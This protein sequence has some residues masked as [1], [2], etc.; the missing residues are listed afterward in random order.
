[1]TEA[2]LI[3][4]KLITKFA[5]DLSKATSYSQDLAQIVSCY[6]SWTTAIGCCLNA[7]YD[8]ISKF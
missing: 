3:C 5:E 6:V 7:K 1:M 4:F 2:V 8:I